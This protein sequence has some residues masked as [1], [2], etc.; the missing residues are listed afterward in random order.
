MES[1]EGVGG[2][3][4]PDG[5]GLQFGC[6]S[7]NQD[8]TSLAVGT[9]TGYKLF[10]LTMVE[11]LDCINESAETPDVYIVERLFS[12]SLIVMVST[13][14]PQRMNIYH[15]K[16]GTEICNYN[17]PNNILAIKLNRQRLVVC[18]E[19]SIYI[20]NIK[21]MKLLKT[22]LNTPINPSGLC[23]LSINHSN[24]YLA[25]PGSA[26]IG[27]IIV[28][29]ANS[30]NTVTMIPAH[31]SPV[32]ALTFNASATKLASASERGTVIR[33]FSVPEGLRL[34]EFRRGMKRYVSISSLSFSPD[35]QFL[36]ASS[37][38]ET[39]HIFKLEQLGPSG[40]DEPNTWTAY[41]GKMFSAASS[42]LPAQV[43]GMMRQDRA[44]AT[45]HLVTSGQRNICTLAIIQKLPRLLVA[46]ADGQ[47]FIYNV[48]PL[49]GGECMLAHKHRL[50][51]TD[52]DQ[53]EGKESEGSEV[54]GPVQA[55]PSYAATAALPAAGPVTATLT[56]YSEDGGV[57][58][59]EVIPEHEFAAGPVSLDDENEFPPVSIQKC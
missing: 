14:M 21:D 52:D 16:K 2:P 1:G 40:G 33:V 36:C 25:Y 51:G 46:T 17:Y 13:T 29:D 42:Y 15:F 5:P 22:L 19:E 18:L 27:E 53:G 48:D 56:G 49:D 23:A 30:L 8:S 57:K 3:G 34:F 6:A 32:A 39:V 11:N 37:N 38:T 20:H 12:S 7:F 41:V 43:S 44:F 9:K 59:G 10:S 45:V 54:T 24:S 50:F 26:T 35:G 28:Y 58:K 4:G 31:D 47:L 55:C